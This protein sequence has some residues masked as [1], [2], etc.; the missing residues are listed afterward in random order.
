MH[1]PAQNLMTRIQKASNDHEIL[2]QWLKKRVKLERTIVKNISSLAKK[3]NKKTQNAFDDNYDLFFEK[4]TQL[5]SIHS[6]TETTLLSMIEQLEHFQDYF[7]NEISKI[8]TEYVR[9]QKGYDKLRERAFTNNI[10]F[11]EKKFES[12]KF[13]TIWKRRE[14]FVHPKEEQQKAF[15]KYESIRDDSFNTYQKYRAVYDNFEQQYQAF[16]NQCQK[17]YLSLKQIEIQRNSLIQQIFFLYASSSKL[18]FHIDIN[19]SFPT[20]PEPNFDFQTKI[21]TLLQDETTQ[22]PPILGISKEI[23]TSLRR[24]FGI[25]KIKFHL[26]KKTKPRRKPPPIPKKKQF[27]LA[28]YDYEPDDL[29]HLPF[30]TGDLIQIVSPTSDPN[31]VIGLL[32]RKKGL[33]PTNY[34]KY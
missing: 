8:N 34:I 12:E 13:Y 11:L 19:Q 23:E 14:S 3:Q 6:E 28:L 22:P 33:V 17:T 32:N 7:K 31:W 1:S 27:A 26:I 2:I 10:K 29:T 5:T 24:N 18:I 21:E 20:T 15:Q 30:N 4:L 9:Q 16:N 25:E